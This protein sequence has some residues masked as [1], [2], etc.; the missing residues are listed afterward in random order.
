MSKL[1]IVILILLLSVGVLGWGYYVGT[2]SGG[3]SKPSNKAV[4]Y[5]ALFYG[6]LLLVDYLLDWAGVGINFF[7]N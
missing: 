3:K 5:L 1:V 6:I 4:F 2:R 7:G